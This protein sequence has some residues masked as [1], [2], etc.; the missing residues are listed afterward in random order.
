MQLLSQ[1]SQFAFF[2]PDSF[3]PQEVEDQFK[4]FLVKKRMIYTSIQD[5]MNA[6]I[7]SV[8]IP[9]YSYSPAEQ[10]INYGK[11]EG[12]Q[13]ATPDQN[14]IS[15][16]MTVTFKDV[17]SHA[18]YLIGQRIWFHHYSRNNVKNQFLGPVSLFSLD[19]NGDAIFRVRFRRC[20]LTGISS[21]DF[22]FASQQIA[23][24]SFSWT[25]YYNYMDTDYLIIDDPQPTRQLLV[26]NIFP[27]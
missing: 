14:L 6:Q 5:Y 20:L 12:Y 1:D 18:A 17:D 4:S 7:R 15:R 25:I 22:N 24:K 8:S 9:G 27:R 23:D 16:T 11:K 3:F 26:E 10:T 21:K 13:P 2:L 19:Q